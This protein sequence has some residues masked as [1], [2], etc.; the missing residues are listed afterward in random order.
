MC[1]D[2]ISLQLAIE[3]GQNPTFTKVWLGK[4]ALQKKN[5]AEIAMN[6]TPVVY[7]CHWQNSLTVC[8]L[9]HAIAK[10]HGYTSLFSG[11]GMCLP[12]S[13]VGAEL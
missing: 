8:V 2:K 7:K 12:A 3:M 10:S 13:D 6:V 9:V 5:L 11:V 1:F 4:A